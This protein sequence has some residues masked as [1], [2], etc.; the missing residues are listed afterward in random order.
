[1]NLYTLSRRATSTTH[2]SLL[3]L[4]FAIPKLQFSE[5]ADYSKKSRVNAYLPP[6]IGDLA[7][8]EASKKPPQLIASA[9]PLTLG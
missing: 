7:V 9:A 3:H 2:P 8:K 4:L 6:N 5:A 1:M